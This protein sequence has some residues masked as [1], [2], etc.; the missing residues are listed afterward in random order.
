MTRPAVGE[1]DPRDPARLAR[2]HA[3]RIALQRFNGAPDPWSDEARGL[4][5]G[6]LGTLGDGAWIEAPLF[7][8]YGHH[9]TVGAETFINTGCV[10]LDAAAIAIGDRVLI[11][12][13]VQLLTVTHPVAARERFSTREVSGSVTPYRTLAAPIVIEDDVWLGAGV[14]VLP[15][16]R[17]GR[18][19]TVGAG[20]VVTRDLPAHVLAVGTPARVVRRL[21]PR[22]VD[23]SR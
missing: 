11:G 23:G 18:G 14:I 5:A 17:I 13:R 16:V 22:D 3:V 15:G 8:E 10:L 20:A 9:V 12:P 2:A 7:C 19:T 1:Y 21:A 4:L 6:V